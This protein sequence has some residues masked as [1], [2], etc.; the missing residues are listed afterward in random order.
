MV[1]RIADLVIIAAFLFTVFS[2]LD[3]QPTTSKSSFSFWAYRTG[4]ANWSDIRFESKPGETSTLSLGKFMKGRV[5]EYQGPRVLTF[6]R[7]AS[8]A[9]AQGSSEWVRKPIASIRI[10]SEV[11]EAILIFTPNRTPAGVEFSITI[12][13]AD[14]MNF[15][16]NSLRILNQTG[17]RL[18]GK[19]G[20]SSQYFNIGI[21]KAFDFSDYRKNGVPVAF[22]VE[23]EEG[24]KF[25]FEKQ[26]QYA[27]NRRVIILLQPPTRKGSYKLQVTNLIEQVE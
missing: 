26:L 5:H 3:G 24:P 16:P 1:R 2:N 10:P 18:A 11:K 25:V 15:P 21:S 4:D 17:T 7:E 23:T 19:V 20:T 9:G 27:L 6:F 12:I 8:V 13:E 22:M 14:Q